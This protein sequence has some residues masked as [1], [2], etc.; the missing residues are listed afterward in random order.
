M[1]ARNINSDWKQNLPTPLSNDEVVGYVY[2]TYDYL[3]FDS[4][5]YNRDITNGHVDKLKASFAERDLGIASPVKT[6]EKG[7]VIDGGHTLEA[8]KQGNFPLY[9]MI[10]PGTSAEQDIARLNMTR[11]DWNYEDWI[12]HYLTRHQHDDDKQK[13]INYVYLTNFRARHKFPMIVQLNL[14]SLSNNDRNI[15]RDLKAGTLTHPDPEE[16]ETRATW[17]GYAA[18]ITKE[19]TREFASAMLFVYNDYN[20]ENNHFLSYLEDKKDSI[21]PYKKTASD[22]IAWFDEKIVNDGKFQRSKKFTG[23]KD[24]FYFRKKWKDHMDLTK[25]MKKKENKTTE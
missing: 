13:F 20:V 4:T 5:D 18:E 9:H 15:Y 19:R 12:K 2:K 25:R 8:R 10:I 14:F 6:N 22:W 24:G 11:K 21:T 16:S 1:D 23:S 3:K 7:E 17:L